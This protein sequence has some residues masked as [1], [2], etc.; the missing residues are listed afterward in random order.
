ME[1]QQIK[2]TFWVII[3]AWLANLVQV[4]VLAHLNL[5]GGQPN[6][7]AIGAVCFLLLGR[8]NLGLIWIYI[9]SGLFDALLGTYGITTAPLLFAYGISYLLLRHIFN[10]LP[11]LATIIIGLI[12]LGSSEVLIAIKYNA[13]VQYIKDL[14][15][16][17]IILGPLTFYIKEK[18]SAY[19]NTINYKF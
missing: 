19:K 14:S 7:I 4:S 16:G 15:F 10:N 1:Y 9:G 11:W 5:F 12:L 17:L 8:T 3:G 6:L 2:N 18:S 13:W